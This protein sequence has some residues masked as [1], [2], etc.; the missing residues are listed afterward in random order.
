MNLANLLIVF[1]DNEC[2]RVFVKR[3]SPNDNSKN[4]VYL[5]GSFDILNILP[6]K[7]I[8]TDSKGDWQRERFKANLEFY[9]TDENGV[10][11]KAPK[12]QLILYPKYPE[13]RFSGFLLGAKGAPTELMVNRIDQRLLFLGVSKNGYIIGYV[14]APDSELS[15]EFDAIS[16]LPEVGVFKEITLE[17]GLLQLNSKKQL[18]DELKRIHQLGWIDS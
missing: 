17:G 18:I 16:D 3:L 9:W 12:A 13:V 1:S 8:T 11:I 4:Q 2:Q 7:E 14:T 15:A 10:L 5:A 6:F